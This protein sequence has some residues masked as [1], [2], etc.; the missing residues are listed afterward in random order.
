MRIKYLSKV[1]TEFLCAI[2]G[3]GQLYL[4]GNT[5]ASWPKCCEHALLA[6]LRKW[7]RLLHSLSI[8]PTLLAIYKVPTHMT[9]SSQQQQQQQ[10]KVNE[11]AKEKQECLAEIVL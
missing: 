1:L 7:Q 11:K 4:K 10:Q 5:P 9:D 8:L 2:A 6:N 3:P